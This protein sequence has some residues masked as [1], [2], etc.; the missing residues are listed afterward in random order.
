[1][2]RERQIERVAARDG[3]SR[4]QA[5]ARIDSQMSVEER[6]ARA[7]VAISTDQPIEKTHEKLAALYHAALRKAD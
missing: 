1:M 7:T 4:E 3:L 2:P 6:N 5:E